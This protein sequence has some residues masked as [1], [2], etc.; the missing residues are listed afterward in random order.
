M[1]RS[2]KQKAITLLT[3]EVIV[4][5]RLVCVAKER[6]QWQEYQDEPL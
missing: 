3:K 4:P 1:R 2:P 6:L 5:K